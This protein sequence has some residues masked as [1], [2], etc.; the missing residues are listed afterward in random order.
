M[1]TA[2]VIRAIRSMTPAKINSRKLLLDLDSW[3]ITSIFGSFAKELRRPPD[4]SVTDIKF[5]SLGG[6]YGINCLIE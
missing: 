4:S 2:Y 3:V 6:P 5:R 1:K